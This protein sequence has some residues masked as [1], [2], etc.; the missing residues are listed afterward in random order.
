MQ[1]LKVQTFVV[2]VRLPVDFQNKRKG[3]KEK[4]AHKERGKGRGYL[5]GRERKN[6]LELI[7]M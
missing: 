1:N 3:K 4:E 7:Y 5:L 6:K 2:T